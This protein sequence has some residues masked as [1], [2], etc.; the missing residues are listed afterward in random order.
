MRR[1]AFALLAVLAVAPLTR[2]EAGRSFGKPLT[3]LTPTPLGDVLARPADGARVCLEG[4]VSVV[5]RNKG[6]WLELKQAGK[7]VHVTFEGY[8]FFVPAELAGK[9]V[10]LEGRVSVAAPDAAHAKHKQQE[11]ASAAAAAKVS[12]VA[13][14]VELK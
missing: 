6:C 3:G 9:T 1:L 14:G 11:G 7:S 13:S 5:C 4:T 10:R 12:V 2:A 8:S